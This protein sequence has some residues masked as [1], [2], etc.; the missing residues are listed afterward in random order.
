MVALVRHLG[1]SELPLLLSGLFLFAASYIFI[2]LAGNVIEGETQQIDEAI[3]LAMRNPEDRSDPIGPA[4]LEETMRDYTALGGTGILTL[5]FAVSLIYLVLRRN[6]EAAI[7]VAAAIA[8]GTLL[9]FLLKQGFDRP[10]PDLVPHGSYVTMASFPSGHSMLSAVTYLTLGVLLAQVHS[11]RRMK[12]FFLLVAML[13]TLLVG[14]S[15]VYLGV[16]W[17]SD[18]LGGWSVGAAWATLCWS[19]ALWLQ[20]RGHVEAESSEDEP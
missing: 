11:R 9:S 1:Q 17:P 4:W 14:I 7:L 19:L 6:F 12:V 15:R 13:V 20:R 10:R 16:H 3:L 8:G 18:V 2:E 5:V